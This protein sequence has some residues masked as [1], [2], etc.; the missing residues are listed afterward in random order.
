MPAAATS[1]DDGLFAG[2]SM[3]LRLGAP[4]G[5]GTIGPP[6]A[7][8][9]P[10]GPDAASAATVPPA[11]DVA[12]PAPMTDPVPQIAPVAAFAPAEFRLSISPLTFADIVNDRVPPSDQPIEPTDDVVEHPDVADVFDHADDALPPIREATPVPPYISDEAGILAPGVSAP[13]VPGPDVAI[14]TTL[15]TL[16]P[17]AVPLLPG[18]DPGP[19]PSAVGPGPTLQ[20]NQ[21]HAPSPMPV[22]SPFALAVPQQSKPNKR[23]GRRGI[24]LVVTLLVLAGVVAAAIVYGRPYLFPDD[25]EANAK[26]YASAVEDVTGVEFTEAVTVTAEPAATFDPR[27]VTH[28]TADWQAQL[29]MWRALGLASGDVT[30]QVL[31]ELLAGWEPA[32]YSTA[33]GQIYHIDTLV[34]AALDAELTDAMTAA[35]LDQQFGWA[36]GQS[37]R[38]LDDAALTEAQVMAQSNATRMA[39]AYST[40][41]DAAPTAPLVYL[42]AVLSYQALA[43]AM[44]AELLAPV[45]PG[46]TNPLDG[47]GAGSPG[48]LPSK[49]PVMAGAPVLA[50]GDVTSAEP[51]AM[52]RSFWY[53]VFA[54]HLDPATAYAASESV[55]ES[56]LT[57]AQRSGTTCAYTTFSGGDLVQTETLRS[58]LESWVGGAPAEQT[59]S[60]AVLPGGDPQMVSCDP[61]PQAAGASRLGVAREL[62]G[63]RS[64][65]LATIA[66]VQAVGGGDGEIAAALDRLAQSTVGAQL[67]G[68]PLD[69]TPVAAAAAAR[70]AVEAVVTPPAP[71]PVTD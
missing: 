29:P 1:D 55:V 17:S 38:T 22:F 35:S 8:E 61:G 32:Q 16:G 3:S 66:G 46:A 45:D 52:D 5:D 56:S 30:P 44:Y 71:P 67:A 10:L 58:A 51:V 13:A 65:E 59:S 25:W 2:I 14:T 37:E 28:L 50:P 6:P 63:W 42:P 43:P 24:R 20:P 21:A 40:Q 47:I 31:G 7:P 26:P 41:L 18:A 69:E 64:A 48:P 23:R 57:V 11:P 70:A 49:V 19:Y 33:D 9:V 39:S 54:G 27:M 68:S 15:P 34:G 4:A 12:A 53:L 60:F 62:I 36:L